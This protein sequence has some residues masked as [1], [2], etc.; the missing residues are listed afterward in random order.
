[1]TVDGYVAI[2]ELIPSNRL[3]VTDSIDASATPQNHVAQIFNSSTGNSADVLAL[4]IGGTGDPLISNNYITFFKGDNATVGSIKGNGSGSIVLG[5]AGSDYAEWLPRLDPAEDI[6]P[7]DVVGVFGGRVSR[8]T[9]GAS[10][11]MAVSSG[12]IVAGNDPGEENRDAYALVAFIGQAPV[13]VRGAVQAGD[14]ILPSGQDDGAAI[15]VA[16][17]ALMLDK[18]D[19]VIGQAWESS[20]VVEEKWVKAAVGLQQGQPA[21]RRLVTTTQEQADRIAILE[22]HN[23]QLEARLAAIERRLNG[24]TAPL[25]SVR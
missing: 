9:T 8:T 22:E 2:G 19:S 12:A 14:F 16:P 21:V 7:G 5:G 25:V 11:V 13:R 6:R 24:S 20:D 1:M 4:K 23:A 10:Q 18:L 15:A 17:Q 3:H